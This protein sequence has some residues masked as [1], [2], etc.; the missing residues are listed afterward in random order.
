MPVFVMKTGFFISVLNSLKN[1]Y[2]TILWKINYQ[3]KDLQAD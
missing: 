2:N 1:L 3:E